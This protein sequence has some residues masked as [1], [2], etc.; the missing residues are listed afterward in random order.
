MELMHMKDRIKNLI[1]ELDTRLLERKELIRLAILSIFSKQHMMLYGVAG[2]G[3]TLAINQIMKII[4]NETAWEILLNDETTLE[5]LIPQPHRP[6]QEVLTDSRCLLS[7]RFVFLDEMF[8]GTQ[9]LL[10]ALL[11][12]LNER[13]YQLGGDTFELKLNSVFAASNEIPQDKFIEPFKD[14]ILFWLDVKSLQDKSNRIKFYTEQFASSTDAL[15][16]SFSVEDI[17]RVDEIVSYTKTIKMTESIAVVYQEIIERLRRGFL[18][19]SDRKTGRNF[20]IKALKVS[21]LLNDRTSINHS[22][23]LLVRHCAW[24]NLS[25]RYSAFKAVDEII[26]G[27]KADIQRNIVQNAHLLY[28]M[29]THYQLELDSFL[30]LLD[31]LKRDEYEN[32]Y[33]LLQ[34]YA[35]KLNAFR[36]NLDA[37]EKAR[38]ESQRILQECLDNVFVGEDVY[39]SNIPYRE[40][41]IR[42]DIDRLVVKFEIEFG[43]MK[44]YLEQYKDFH[45]YQELFRLQEEERRM[46]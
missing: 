36:A 23:L 4:Q 11:P 27:S 43:K 21:A 40:E 46:A 31:S 34:E 39:K 38:D 3:K 12:I 28:N 19:I 29:M 14:R 18:G 22:D 37:I 35:E 2:V 42:D 24:T 16:D 8:K 7:R 44:Q 45:T 15:Q 9:Q 26:F 25:Q 20:I 10:N 13:R 1:D 5:S 17:E 30:G 41:R 32:K 33:Q 6:P